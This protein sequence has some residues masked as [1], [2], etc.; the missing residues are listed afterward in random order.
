MTLG[1]AHT[2]VKAVNCLVVIKYLAL[3]RPALTYAI[4]VR[5]VRLQLGH[6]P[7]PELNVCGSIAVVNVLY[8]V[9]SEAVNTKIKVILSY[10]EHFF[11][12]LGVIVVKLG[13]IA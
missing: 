7:V 5:L 3:S 12:N 1:T 13:H 2:K 6:I 9:K 8:R 10:V 11:L 4:D